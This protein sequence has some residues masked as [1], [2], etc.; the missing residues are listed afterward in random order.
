MAYTPYTSNSSSNAL[1]EK[2]LS[3][4]SYELPPQVLQGIV[5]GWGAGFDLYDFL[6]IAGSRF[7]LKG[8]SLRTFEIY[9]FEKLITLAD[10]GSGVGIAT[11]SSGADITFKLDSGDY[12]SNGNAVLRVSDH[13]LVPSA[14]ISGSVNGMDYEYRINSITGSGAAKVYTASPL[15]ANSSTTGFTAAQITVAVPIGT[16]L[17]ITTDSH[18]LGTDVPKGLTSHSLYYDFLTGTHKS[19]FQISGGMQSQESYL[20]NVPLRGGKGTGR[21]NL[22]A[23]QHQFD[24]NRKINYSMWTGQENDNSA[25]TVTN[26]NGETVKANATRGLL[27]WL[28]KRAGQYQYQDKFEIFDLDEIAQYHLSQGVLAQEVMIGCGDLAYTSIEN[29]NYSFIKEYG[30]DNVMTKMDE[31]G[32]NFRVIKKNNFNYVMKQFWTLSNPNGLGS[33][34]YANKYRNMMFTIPMGE[35]KVTIAN[36]PLMDGEV[37]LGNL[38]LGYPDHGGENREYQIEYFN[39][40]TGLDGFGKPV[41]TADWAEGVIQSEHMLIATKVNQMMLIQQAQ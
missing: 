41:W 20:E 5:K 9:P 8:R 32:L 19:T 29:S 38:M 26:F 25:L 7:G 21:V 30:H 10:V 14:Y 39:G 2:E 23:I 28:Y 15:L 18:G 12:D 35:N 11:N 4:Y 27:P 17:A 34:A 16:K 6:N 37:K 22:L 31:I 24:H 1:T 13:I 3:L 40:M 33:A 36:G